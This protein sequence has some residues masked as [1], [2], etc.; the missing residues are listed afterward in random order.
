MRWKPKIEPHAVRWSTSITA[1]KRAPL[2][3]RRGEL[4]AVL[5]GFVEALV[6]AG[7]DRREVCQALLGAE[8]ECYRR[9]REEEEE[10]GPRKRSA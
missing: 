2:A 5:D 8:R 9:R 3:H 7:Y 6:S 10:M 1:S 4:A